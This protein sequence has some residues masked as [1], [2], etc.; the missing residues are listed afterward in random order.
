LNSLTKCKVLITSTYFSNQ[1]TREQLEYRINRIGQIYKEVD[2]ITYT[3][4]ILHG[5]NQRYNETRKLSLAIKDFADDIN[6]NEL[7]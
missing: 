7:I 6:V 2:I 1:A 3:A 4:G 5:I